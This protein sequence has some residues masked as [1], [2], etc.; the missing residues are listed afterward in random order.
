MF[1]EQVETRALLLGQAVP[2]IL[3][4]KW[5]RPRI[6]HAD[7]IVKTAWGASLIRASRGKFV[8]N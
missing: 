3:V 1:D 4:M 8:P 5:V 2:T 7:T 6:I